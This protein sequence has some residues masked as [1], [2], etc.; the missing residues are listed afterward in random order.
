M[1]LEAVIKRLWRSSWRSCSSEF[2]DALEGLNCTRLQEDLEVANLKTVSSEGR[3]DGSGDSIYWL[4]GNC[5]S[6]TN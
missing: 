2:A 1:Q 5:V 6:L 3:C 4:T